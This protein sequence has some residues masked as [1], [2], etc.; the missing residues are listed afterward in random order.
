MPQPLAE[1]EII[2]VG[3]IVAIDCVDWGSYAD[4]HSRAEPFSI[5]KAMV[6]GEVIAH[7]QDGEGVVIAP[8]V[9]DDSDVRFTLVVPLCTVKRFFVLTTRAE[10]EA[11]P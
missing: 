4:Q 6:Y 5:T 10:L 9:F 3:D 8:Q 1:G 11:M 2:N 7:T